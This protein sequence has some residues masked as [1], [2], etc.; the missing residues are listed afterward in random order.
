[1]SVWSKAIKCSSLII[2]QPQIGQVL[3]NGR[4]VIHT[5]CITIAPNLFHGNGHQSHYRPDHRIRLSPDHKPKIPISLKAHK[6]DFGG[7]FGIRV[8]Y[9]VFGCVCWIWYLGGSM[10]ACSLQKVFYV[11]ILIHT[12][13]FTHHKWPCETKNVFCIWVG[14]MYFVFGV[15]FLQKCIIVVPLLVSSFSRDPTNP[16]TPGHRWFW[17][18][19]LQLWF[20]DNMSHWI[21]SVQR[22][23]CEIDLI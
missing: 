11:C 3:V 15:S 18:I 1:M 22:W 16:L 6:M 7:V 10:F 5:Y 23:L 9:F 14:Y 12:S 2:G 20:Y 19:N 4:F 13:S 21:H 17:S 8:L